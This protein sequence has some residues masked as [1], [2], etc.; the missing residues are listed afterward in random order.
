MIILT[1]E[2]NDLNKVKYIERWGSG[3]IDILRWCIE[4][5]LPEPLFKEDHNGFSVV[6]RKYKITDEV[7]ETL[8]ER[9]RKAV[10]YIL[11]H[12][13]ITNK[14]Y[15]IQCPEVSRETLRKDLNELIKQKIIFK[16][17]TKRGIY[18]KLA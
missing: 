4:D 18:Y 8:N 13:Q 10:K 7:L 3:T 9:Q 12:S 17:G 14:N 11:E 16:K 1:V 5:N 15:K 6:L 2:I